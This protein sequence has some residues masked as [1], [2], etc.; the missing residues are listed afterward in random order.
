M[1]RPQLFGLIATALLASCGE[2]EPTSDAIDTPRQANP[3]PIVVYASYPDE[4]YL[5]RLF[6][7]FT[8]ETGIRVTVKYADAGK[9]VDDVIAK[10]GSPPADLLLT[11]SVFGAWR[12]A[13]EGALRPI[14]SAVID[15]SVPEI[16][17]DPDGYWTAVSIRP[18]MIY[19]DARQTSS[20]EISGFEDLAKPEFKGKLCLT[21]SALDV[22]RSLIAKLIRVHGNRPAEIIVRGWVANLA[23]PAFETESDLMGALK[24]GTCGI[25]AVP[26][27]VGRNRIASTD[28][29]DLREIRPNFMHGNVEAAG[30]NRHAREPAAARLL[31]EWMLTHRV[32]ANHA[33]ATGA[34]PVIGEA[35]EW[36]GGNVGATAWLDEDAVKLAER[37]GYR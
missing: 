18:W 10:R 34:E 29:S 4:S 21:S 7:G 20:P 35:S 5:P 1:T 2:S 13:D 27:S 19:F 24:A 17:R 36:T 15:E 23:L 9:N 3:E 28:I 22:N 32:Q 16:M 37:A 25:G 12:A 30:L 14:G 31:L 8:E 11:P 33:A 6:E 26:V